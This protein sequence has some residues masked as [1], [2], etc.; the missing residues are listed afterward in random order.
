M[1]AGGRFEVERGGAERPDAI[2]ETDPATLGALVYEG[3]QLDEALRS[4]DIKIE[5][6]R[7]A[8]ERFL[9]LFPL[10]ASAATAVGT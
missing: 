5:G 6:D 7:S 2:I 10:P 8:V 1:V 3:R 4:G 9:G